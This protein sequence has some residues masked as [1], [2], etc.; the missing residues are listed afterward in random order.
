MH[1]LARLVA[2]PV[3]GVDGEAVMIAS[4]GLVSKLVVHTG[5][6]PLIATGTA[7]AAIGLLWL[8]CFR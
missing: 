1:G 5:I 3:G 6:R 4:A 2:T 7:I 8:K